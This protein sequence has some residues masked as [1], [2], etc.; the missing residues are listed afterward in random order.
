MT[1]GVKKLDAVEL[2][3]TLWDTLNA[4]KGGSMTPQAA[5]SVAVTSREILRTVKMQLAI[6]QQANE[7]VPRELIDFAKP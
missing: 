2:K 3:L 4:V 6:C 1:E 7:N 5:D